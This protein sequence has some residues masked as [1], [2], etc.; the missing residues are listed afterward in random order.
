[1]RLIALLLISALAGVAPAQSEVQVHT[2]FEAREGRRNLA[3]GLNALSD[4]STQVPFI[5]QMRTAREWMGHLPGQWGGRDIDWLREGGYLDEDGWI[6]RMPTSL[7]QIGTLIL[8]DLPADMTSLSGRYHARWEGSAYP[9]FRGA[10]N[11]VRY[12]RNAATF[13]FEPGKGPVLI[14]IQRG[15]LRNLTVVHERHLERF[16]AGEIFN[17]DWLAHIHDAETLR[18]MDWMTT[19]DSDQG[20]W[21]DRPRLSDYTWSTHGAPLEI[22][23]ELANLTGAE[24]WF[25]L[26]HGA[27]DDYMRRFA[28]MVHEGLRPDLRAWIE[29]SNEVWNWQFAQAD[30]AEQAAR[31]R[32]GG[33][34][35]G[36]VQFYA[37]RALEMVQIWNEVFAEQ[38]ER[39]VRVLS[40]QTGWIG[41]EQDILH[42]PLWQAESPG[43]RPPYESF[44]VYAVTG[45]FGGGLH[46]DERQP[47]VD[48]WLAQSR[49]QA[50]AAAQALPADEREGH[51]AAHRFDLALDLAARELLD[52]SVSGDR[53]GT[54]RQGLDEILPYHAQVAQQHG[55]TMVMYE[56]GTHVIVPTNR[57]DDSDLVDFVIAFNHSPQMADLYREFVPGWQALTEAPFNAF[58]DIGLPSIWG[59]W[60]ALRHVDDDNPRWDALMDVTA[61]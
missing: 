25:N 23:L 6:V 45:Y 9:A 17:P 5:D 22:M 13:D 56:G 12:Q 54:V 19:N 28:E 24:P 49:A 35:W 52:G 11:N 42:A 29:L 4:F 51:I 41:L 55:L 46:A 20:E 53:A 31:A 50:E 10:A 36:W 7:S 58:V 8:T 40:V 16:D 60:G 37:L 48:D 34:E 27:S 39:L 59:S 33:R 26:P 47:M 43:N 18:F 3:F 57:H 14:G 1:M 30:W 2:G 38:P 32:W 21:P 61:P 15:D 44:D